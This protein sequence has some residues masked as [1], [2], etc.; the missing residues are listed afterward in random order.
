ME[1]DTRHDVATSASGDVELRRLIGEDVPAWMIACLVVVGVLLAIISTHAGLSGAVAPPRVVAI[2]EPTADEERQ[3]LR[4]LDEMLRSQGAE[5]P[6]APPRSEPVVPRSEAATAPIGSCLPAVDVLFAH[7][8]TRLNPA[9]LESRID[10]LRR[11]MEEHPEAVML[12]EG[13][14]DATGLERHN[15]LLSYRRAKV[16]EE[17]LGREGLPGKRMTIRAAGSSEAGEPSSEESDE[18][19][20]NNRRASVRVEGVDVCKEAEGADTQ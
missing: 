4:V 10:R 13:H 19:L 5:E 11:W 15:I 16:V 7:D 8:S 20:A 18:R 6:R 2:A 3:A 9:V 17:W 14:A 12:I 1:D